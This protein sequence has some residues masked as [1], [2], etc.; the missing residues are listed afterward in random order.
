MLIA[1]KRACSSSLPQSL[2]VGI[3]LIFD[4]TNIF[5]SDKQ[6]LSPQFSSSGMWR[7]INV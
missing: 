2:V 7:C 1:F 6:L 4:L 5:C 3:N